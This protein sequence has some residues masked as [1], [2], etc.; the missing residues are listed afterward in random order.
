MCYVQCMLWTSTQVLHCT[1]V[2]VSSY[3]LFE[4]YVNVK[5]KCEIYVDILMS[6]IVLC[7]M[8]ERTHPTA[9]LMPRML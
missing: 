1:C 4:P 9:H 6:S 3:A 7:S 5:C 2:Y 8:G